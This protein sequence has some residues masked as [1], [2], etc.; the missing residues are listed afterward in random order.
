[1]LQI[2]RVVDPRGLWLGYRVGRYSIT[3]GGFA[4]ANLHDPLAK[5]EEAISGE[6][7]DLPNYL[8]LPIAV[9]DHNR[10]QLL[11]YYCKKGTTLEMMLFGS[12]KR[13]ACRCNY[14]T[15]L[16]RPTEN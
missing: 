10:S 13:L 9:R 12:G 3:Y 2:I 11:C 4:K 5:P 7:N 6:V 14:C 1:M 15:R 8:D 16:S